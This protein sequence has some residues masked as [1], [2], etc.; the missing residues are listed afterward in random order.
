MRAIF[1]KLF[2]WNSA[3]N[4]GSGCDAS[5][6]SPKW[7]GYLVGS[8]RASLD[9]ASVDTILFWVRIGSMAWVTALDPPGYMASG[10]LPDDRRCWSRFTAW[11]GSFWSFWVSRRTSRPRIPPLALMSLTAAVRPCTSPAV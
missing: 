2:F 1:L 11:V 7:Y 8:F 10:F 5:V 6:E 3:T 9:V 4:A